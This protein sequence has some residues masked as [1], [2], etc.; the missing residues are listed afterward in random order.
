MSYPLMCGG[1]HGL[2]LIV[3]PATRGRSRW[4]GFTFP[5]Q[6][7]S[8]IRIYGHTFLSLFVVSTCLQVFLVKLVNMCLWPHVVRTLLKL[9][10]ETT[11]QFKCELF[12]FL[13]VGC[14]CVKLKWGNYTNPGHSPELSTRS[15]WCNTSVSDKKCLQLL[16]MASHEGGAEREV[17][18]CN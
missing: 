5:E 14:K 3:Q 6:S 9:T 2:R 1:G 15:Q 10:R 4:F 12:F 11:Y 13:L 8:S 17:K 18:R 7:K 16:L